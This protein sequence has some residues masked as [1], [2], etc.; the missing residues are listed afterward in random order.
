MTIYGT[1]FYSATVAKI[2]GVSTPLTTTVL[3]PTALLAVVPASLLI[4]SGTLQF[5]AGKSA[6][7]RRFRCLRPIAVTS[8][9]TIAGVFNAASYFSATI[10]PGEL[11]TIFGTNIGPAIPASMT[12]S[13]GFVSTSL[14]ACPSPSMVRLPR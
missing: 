1:S 11:V 4:A 6:T 5:I 3:S 8:A 2:Q 12:I 13:G 9:P 10:S 7:G 14:N